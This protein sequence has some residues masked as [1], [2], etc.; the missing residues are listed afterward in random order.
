MWKGSELYL[1]IYQLDTNWMTLAE[2]FDFDISSEGMDS[3]PAKIATQMSSVGAA[4]SGL[5]VV[6]TFAY[7]F[8]LLR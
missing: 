6:G 2:E 4:L 1:Q 5:S 3:I 8:R 7:L